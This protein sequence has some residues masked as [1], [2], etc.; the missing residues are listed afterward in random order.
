MEV[1]AGMA[2]YVVFLGLFIA[3]KFVAAKIQEKYSTFREAR[4]AAL[5][6]AE[7]N[8]GMMVTVKDLNDKVLEEFKGKAFQDRRNM[9][10]N[11]KAKMAKMP[12]GLSP[13]NQLRKNAHEENLLNL[14]YGSTKENKNIK[15]DKIKSNINMQ[16]ETDYRGFMKQ[17]SLETGVPVENIP[18][19]LNQYTEQSKNVNSIGNLR[20]RLLKSLPQIKSTTL[21]ANKNANANPTEN[22]MYGNL[23]GGRRLKNRT[24]RRRNGRRTNT[25]R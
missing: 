13:N 5:R 7:E 19:T 4:D 17:L 24:K 6:L 25:R 20:E 10:N 12:N 16:K 22:E 8:P 11:I 1:V 23:H 9:Y 21:V 14:V 2:G 18:L 3:G 15:L